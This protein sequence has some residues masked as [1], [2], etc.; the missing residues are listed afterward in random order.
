LQG[1]GRAVRVRSA[2]LQQR[3]ADEASSAEARAAATIAAVLDPIGVISVEELTRRRERL[4][5][6]EARATTASGA[7][8][9]ERAAQRD[10][11]QAAAR[12]DALAAALVPDVSGDR[13]AQRAAIVLRAARKRERVGIDA[14][15][16]F[17][18]V[19]RSTILGNDDEYA[20][21]NELADLLAAGVE[22]IEDPALSLRQI[23]DERSAIVE[24]LRGIERDLARMQGEL[25]S[26]ER[27]IPNLAE[28]DEAIARSEAEVGRLEAFERALTLAKDTLQRRTDEAHSSFARRLEDYAAGTFSTITAGRY[29][30][31]RVNPAT[32]EITVRVPETQSIEKID[33]LS[34]GT[35]DQAFLV[36][37]FAMAR[38]FAEGIETPPLLLDDPFAYWD[39][40]RIER[41]LPIVERGALDGQTLLFT[42]SE[43]LA[44]AAAARGALRIDL[45]TPA[46][47]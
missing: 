13:A 43:E 17:L 7:V 12:F 25:G 28:L 23:E 46:I 33:A 40:A 45:S 29:G 2:A 42:S 19:Q 24:N 41:C 21:E 44:R 35:R 3:K 4:A 16:S 36:V 1:R 18:D 26:A 22:P 27:A 47:A 15:L 34:A 32:L 14:R 9:R 10:A 38:M 31:L 37:R 11:E 39:A 20:L 30:E 6:L 8:E 5:E